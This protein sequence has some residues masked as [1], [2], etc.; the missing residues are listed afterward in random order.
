[1]K[2]YT[3]QKP[4]PLP[5]SVNVAYPSTSTA[6]AL[7]VPTGAKVVRVRSATAFFL[8][9]LS[10]PTTSVPAAAPTTSGVADGEG[11]IRVAANTEFLADIEGVSSISLL[12]SAGI[13]AV[14]GEFWGDK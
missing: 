4:V 2:P 12:S 1:M 9:N 6:V 11:S 14:L 3:Q 13:I 10:P 5:D 7:T 8:R